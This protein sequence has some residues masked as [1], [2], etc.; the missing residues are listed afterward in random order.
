MSKFFIVICPCRD[1]V[2]S[3]F[4]LVEVL[5]VDVLSMSRFFPCRGF[6]FVEILSLSKFCPVEVLSCRGFVC[7]GLV[8]VPGRKLL[9]PDQR[10]TVR[11]SVCLEKNK[12]L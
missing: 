9:H 4:C 12:S 11:Y 8:L 5:S 1:F 2:L 6:V 3:R 7:R 10:R